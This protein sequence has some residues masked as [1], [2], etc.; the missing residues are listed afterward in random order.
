MADAAGRTVRNTMKKM[1]TSVRSRLSSST[2]VQDERGLSTV[3][4]VILL[5][6]IA[7]AC[8]ALWVKLGGTIQRKIGEANDKIDEEVVVES[9]KTEK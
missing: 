6:L 1:L 3:E 2:I 5:V 4:Y 7:A 8:V 9:E